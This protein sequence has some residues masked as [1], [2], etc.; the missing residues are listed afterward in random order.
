MPGPDAHSASGDPARSAD[1]LAH[2]HPPLAE[3]PE[4]ADA[5]ARL[6]EADRLIARAVD[7]IAR[8]DEETAS[9]ALTGVSLTDWLT[10]V[11]RRTGTDA[12][13]LVTS[14]R[15]CRRIPALRAGFLAGRLSWAQVRSVALRVHRLPHALDDVVDDAV[16]RVVAASPHGE[17][18]AIVRA[19]A[20]AVDSV[21]TTSPQRRERGAPKEEFLAMQPRMD[22]SGGQL[23][24]DLGPA[25]W[26]TLDA[27][28][29]TGLSAADAPRPGGEDGVDD[30][31]PRTRPMARAR[32]ARLVRILDASMSDGTPSPSAAPAAM[33]AR[34]Q[35]LLRAE[36]TDLLDGARTPA[37]VLTSL[38]GGRVWMNARAARR[39]LDERGADVRTVVID[40]TGSVVG[41][42]R[43]A[44]LAPGW[45]R[46]AT[47][48][49]HDT[50]SAPN[51]ERPARACHTDH[52]RPWHPA[53]PS[54]R[55]GRTDLDELAPL[56]NHHNGN[57]E[58][59]GWRVC[60]QP[61]G[62]RTW[63][64][65][66]SGITTQTLPATWRPPD[67]HLERRVRVS[68]AGE[69][70]G[71]YGVAQHPAH[72]TPIRRTPGRDPTSRRR[73]D[74]RHTFA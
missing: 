18:D 23:F 66:R 55:A 28:L 26:A 67:P 35:L 69:E 73:A 52:A 51:C 48:A 72:H 16:A 20:Q 65:E 9:H 19:I 42:G 6:L 24:G 47:L 37:T 63:W 21:D 62:T 54:D 15:I 44:R 3:L 59:D 2:R 50:C 36:L 74:V 4:L 27:A 60:Q 41:V 22:G 58:R 17:P 7:E 71:T 38:F 12:R 14:A 25:S 11:A 56:C 45:L 5:L 53:R 30:M 10:L 70:P 39:L 8:I 61:D 64:H 31:A 49:V 32:L 46:D 33:A 68:M 13:M 40:E 57:K 29:N 34:P 43:R 1:E